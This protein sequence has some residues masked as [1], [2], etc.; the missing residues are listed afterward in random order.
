MSRLK[1]HFTHPYCNQRFRRL[2]FLG[3]SSTPG[4]FSACGMRMQIPETK[5]LTSEDPDVITCLNCQ[6]AF[7]HVLATAGELRPGFRF[8]SGET[9]VTVKTRWV[10]ID[11][12]DVLYVFEDMKQN[13]TDSSW[14]A[15]FRY[16][17]RKR[18]YAYTRDCDSDKMFLKL[19]D[20]FGFEFES[21]QEKVD[22]VKSAFNMNEWDAIEFM[23]NDQ[24]GL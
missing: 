7:E 13:L 11:M 15:R 18:V 5:L 12:P 2:E 17:K 24:F 6:G 1:V 22:I 23:I 16:L 4:T 8:K 20:R 10:H 21:D 3:N 9:K 14:G 19:M